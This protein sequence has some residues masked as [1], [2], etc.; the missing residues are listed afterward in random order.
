MFPYRIGEVLNWGLAWHSLLN[1]HSFFLT[2]IFFFFML[3]SKIRFAKWQLVCMNLMTKEVSYVIYD[4]DNSVKT[5]HC[6]REGKYG[7]KEYHVASQSK[8]E[9]MGSGFGW[10][11]VKQAHAC[12]TSFKTEATLNLCVFLPFGAQVFIKTGIAGPDLTQFLL[13]RGVKGKALCCPATKWCLCCLKAVWAASYWCF[14]SCL[15]HSLV[16][17][18]TLLIWI[19]RSF[20]FSY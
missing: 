12:F 14:R 5:V 20:V 17:Y 2:Q 16:H 18:S 11:W 19:R 8:F 3:L 9:L 4:A 6:R 15:H 10:V 7:K 13:L 1:F